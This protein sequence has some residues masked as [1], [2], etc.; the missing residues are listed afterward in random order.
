MALQ[1]LPCAGLIAGR[2]A[3]FENIG[4]DHENKGVFWAAPEIK[5]VTSEQT[6]ATVLK[7]AKIIGFGKKSNP[8]FTL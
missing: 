3:I 8:P 4:W 5:I 6:H 1:L 7:A 2:Y